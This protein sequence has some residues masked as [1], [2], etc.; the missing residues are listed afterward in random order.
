MAD[1]RLSAAA[2]SDIEAI[3]LYT[4]DTFGP[5][6]ADKY[7]GGLDETLQR[8]AAI[9]QMGRKADDLRKGLF[10]YLYQSHMIFYTIEQDEIVI[11]RVLH[12]RMDF[13]SR[14]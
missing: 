11:R 13:G 3:Y 12:A 4:F 14:L 8:L 6:Q 5:R 2:Q 10:R 9:P 7:L 1:Y